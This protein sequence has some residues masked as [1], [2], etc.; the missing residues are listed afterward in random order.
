MRHDFVADWK[1][2][3]HNRQQVDAR[4]IAANR[5]HFSHDYQVGD[6][7]LKLVYDPQKL[8]PRATVPYRIN[9]IHTN[10]TITIHNYNKNNVQNR[11][12]SICLSNKD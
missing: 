9:T 8:A 3:C 1:L 11:F 6:E 4:P 7:V 5:K 10:G 2:I 12:K